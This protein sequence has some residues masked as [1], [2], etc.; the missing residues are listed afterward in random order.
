MHTATFTINY[1]EQC[2]FSTQ[3]VSPHTSTKLWGGG[4][5]KV[6][7]YLKSTTIFMGGGVFLV[8]QIQSFKFS[9]RSSNPKGGAF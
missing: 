3:R 8:A 4:R 2:F 9:M 5:F 1:V 7:S 6:D